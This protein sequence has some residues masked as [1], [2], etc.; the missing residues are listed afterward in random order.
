MFRVEFFFRLT[1][2]RSLSF[3][4]FVTFSRLTSESFLNALSSSKVFVYAACF[5]IFCHGTFALFRPSSLLLLF[6]L[7]FLLLMNNE[8]CEYL[9][10]NANK[11]S[12]WIALIIRDLYYIFVSF[13][14]VLAAHT[15]VP[16]TLF[17]ATR[18]HSSR[19]INF[20]TASCCTLF[21]AVFMIVLLYSSLTRVTVGALNTQRDT[22]KE[23][24]IAFVIARF[25][26]D[27]NMESCTHKWRIP[28][29][30]IECRT[31]PGTSERVCACFF[32]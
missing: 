20:N 4:V 28:N 18:N 13:C 2:R 17:S 1:L 9:H 30:T 11:P 12:S 22:E 16:I 8:I 25:H 5:D 14:L 7:L 29:Q 21:Q 31:A 19:S 3:C 6:L 32:L 15:M 26:V 24:E 23:R 10:S 27:K